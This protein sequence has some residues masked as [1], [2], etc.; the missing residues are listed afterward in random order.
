MQTAQLWWR[1][2]GKG[3]SRCAVRRASKLITVLLHIVYFTLAKHS[4]RVVPVGDLQEQIRSMTAFSNILVGL[5]LCVCRSYGEYIA[6]QFD[7]TARL[8]LV[9]HN[10]LPQCNAKLGL[11]AQRKCLLAS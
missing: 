9:S 10:L 3:E 1:F 6:H 7:T 11:V 2:V 8:V 4:L 5:D